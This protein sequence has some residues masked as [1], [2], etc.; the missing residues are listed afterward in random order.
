VVTEPNAVKIPDV[1]AFPEPSPQPGAPEQ[2]VAEAEPAPLPRVAR[3]RGEPRR[4]AAAP[5]SPKSASVPPRPVGLPHVPPAPDSIRSEATAPPPL[6]P[7][8]SDQVPADLASDDAEY[9][10]ASRLAGLRNLLV[11]LGRRSLRDGEIAAESDSDLEPRF[12]KATVRPAYSDTPLPAADVRENGASARLIAQPE[13][14]PP[15][16]VAADV[17]KEKE[18]VRPTPPRREN[19]DG[20]EIQTLPSWRG[21]YRKKRYP[22][23]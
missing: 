14:L 11:T 2:L 5:R 19:W 4:P 20:D 21:Q 9:A 17:E 3:G 1:S 18:V 16:P 15:K 12:A 23:I 7:A 8:G 13:F 22:P 10:P 6:P